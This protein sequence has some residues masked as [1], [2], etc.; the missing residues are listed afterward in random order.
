MCLFTEP[1]GRQLQSASEEGSLLTECDG[2][3]AGETPTG[4]AAAWFL[5]SVFS[6]VVLENCSSSRKGNLRSAFLSSVTFPG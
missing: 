4:G 2:R 6:G 3:L 5:H 1:R